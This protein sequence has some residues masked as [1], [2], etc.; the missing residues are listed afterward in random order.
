MGGNGCKRTGVGYRERKTGGN[1]RIFPVLPP[2]FCLLSFISVAF[3]S[4]PEHLF[5]VDLTWEG[6]QVRQ[7]LV[8]ICFIRSL[9]GHAPFP[10]GWV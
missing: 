7:Y 1:A 8:P 6:A 9:I 3:R 4:V 2:A 5:H 10:D